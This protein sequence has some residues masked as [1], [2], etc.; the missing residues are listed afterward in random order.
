ML[1]TE[2]TIYFNEARSGDTINIGKPALLTVK[3]TGVHDVR[4][5]YITYEIDER[6]P[7][8]TMLQE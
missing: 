3:S 1:M 5:P 2:V 8:Q 4:G 6:L 7:S